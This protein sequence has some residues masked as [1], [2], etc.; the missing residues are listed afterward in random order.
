MGDG[1]AGRVQQSFHRGGA[2]L[3]PESAPV[4]RLVDAVDS[5]EGGRIGAHD[6]RVK[7]VESGIAGIGRQIVGNASGQAGDCPA[8]AGNLREGGALVGAAED[9]DVVVRTGQRAL[10]TATRMVFPRAATPMTFFWRERPRRRFATRS[11][12]RR[13]CTQP[14][15]IAAEA[16][17]LAETSDPGHHGLARGIGRIE[18]DR[19]DRQRFIRIG[20]FR[21]RGTGG[22]GIRGLPNAAVG[23]SNV[24]DIGIGRMGG[25]GLNGAGHFVQV[26]A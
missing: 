23:R 17:K 14:G 16:I 1:C 22:R 26:R 6:C 8:A 18:S 4:G 7:R 25:H 11:L 13:S 21:P 5:A 9:S 20:Q 19:A 2:D 10:S 3:G 24:K 12:R 15:E